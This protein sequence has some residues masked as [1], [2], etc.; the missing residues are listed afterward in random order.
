MVTQWMRIALAPCRFG[1]AGYDSTSGQGNALFTNKSVPK[2]TRKLCLPF[3]AQNGPETQSKRPNE[4]KW[5][6]QGTCALIAP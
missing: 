4:G 5:L 2:K 6:L 3:L 1:S